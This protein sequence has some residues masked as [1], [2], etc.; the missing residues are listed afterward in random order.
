[1]RDGTKTVNICRYQVKAGHEA[2]MEALLVKHWPALHGAGLT[3]DEPA[4]VYRGVPSTKPNQEHGAA[5]VYIEIFCWKSDDAP[6]LAHEMPEVMAVWEPM[7]A[8]CESMEFP[9]FELLDLLG[10]DE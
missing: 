10:P 2:E 4:T 9:S 8:I 1:M 7:G 5:R 6:A 3:T